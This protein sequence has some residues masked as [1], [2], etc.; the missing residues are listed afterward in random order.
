MSERPDEGRNPGSEPDPAHL[1]VAAAALTFSVPAFPLPGQT[2]ESPGV[3][4]EVPQQ[5][6]SRVQL[7]L[8][9]LVWCA[10]LGAL[11]YA[12]VWVGREMALVG[13]PVT[14]AVDGHEEVVR[15]AR[16]DVAG[17]LADLGLTLRPEDALAPAAQ[18]PVS[19]G[20]RITVERARRGLVSSDGRLSEVFTHSATAGGLLAASGIAVSPQ[21]EVLLDGEVVPLDT[22]LPSIH[23]AEP[24]A[25]LPLGRAWNVPAPQPVHLSIRRAAPIT[26]DD[27]TVPYTLYTTAATVGDALLREEVTLYLGDRVQ[28]NLGARVN[29]GMRIYIERSK[30]VLVA[31]DG[32]TVQTRTRGKTVGAALMD[33]G[34]VTVGMDEVTPA[35]HEKLI[36][37]MQIK[38]TRVNEVTLVDST[39]IPFES[40]SVPDDNLEL[41]HT[42]LAQAGKNGEYRKRWKVRYED[43]QEVTRSLIDEWQAAAPVTRITAYGRMLVPRTIETEVG[44][45]TYWR[46]IRMYATSYSPARSGTPK[47]AAWYGRTRIGQPLRK[48]LVAVDTSIIPFHTPLY[49][50]GY[51]TA[52][53]ADTGGGVRGKWIDLGFSDGDYESWHWWVDVYVLE[54]RSPR[55]RITWVLPNYPPAS[56][57]RKK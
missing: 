19:E 17:I 46:K 52:I 30:P 55:S 10:A 11:A 23:A 12:G 14:V 20:L 24:P 31:A 50:P 2:L 21:D 22:A 25:G 5:L 36:D 53:A 42:K 49:I 16:S 34:I 26:V 43:G 37:K 1:S 8:T 7:W 51:G 39:A 27:G 38:V 47:T 28:P 54:P 56:Y 4:R 6:P 15:T 40:I 45:L 9:V 33:L 3:A 35:L 48:G 29:P 57:P 41:D 18:T 32:H 44:T 13:V